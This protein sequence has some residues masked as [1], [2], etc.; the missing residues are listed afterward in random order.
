[1]NVRPAKI[2]FILILNLNNDSISRD[3]LYKIVVTGITLIAFLLSSPLTQPVKAADKSGKEIQ[4]AD[5]PQK[6]KAP[7]KAKSPSKPKS[8]PKPHIKPPPKP[9]LPK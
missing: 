6:P 2:Q 8:P 4:K 9:P 1:M 7:P 3:L 5:S